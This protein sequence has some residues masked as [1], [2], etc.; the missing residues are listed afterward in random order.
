MIEKAILAFVILLVVT[1]IVCL[2]IGEITA[3]AKPE[4][5]TETTAPK[6]PELD[7]VTVWDVPMPEEHQEIVRYWCQ[8]LDVD[9]RMV[10][11]VIF[12]E[13]NFDQY[14]INPETGCFGY[15]QLNR[16]IYDYDRFCEPERNL[17]AGIAELARLRCIYRDATMV[18]LCYNNGEAGAHRLIAKGVTST[19]YTR[20]VLKY[21]DKI[22]VKGL[23][24]EVTK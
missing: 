18:L 13:S 17:Y 10:Y 19:E 2:I 12:A 3:G 16:D 4:T 20:K 1:L 7:V 21:A 23:L 22:K 11:G 15:M 9:E 24:Y 14:A 6:E 8:Q 5:I